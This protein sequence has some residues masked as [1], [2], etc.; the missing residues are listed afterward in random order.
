MLITLVASEG[1]SAQSA[2]RAHEPA[3]HGQ[4]EVP[5]HYLST[6]AA[7][8]T[9]GGYMGMFGLG[10]PLTYPTQQLTPWGMNPYLTQGAG[11]T[12][13]GMNPFSSSQFVPQQYG[14]LGLGTIGGTQ[15]L[16]QILPQVIQLLQ[17]VPQQLHQLQQVL[18]FIPAQLQQLQQL[19]QYVPQQIQQ[20]QQSQHQPFGQSGLG[21]FSPWGITPQGFGAQSGPVM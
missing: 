3:S 12:P 20:L 6:T 17:T 9:E 7:D 19:I 14:Q 4:H 21:G 11:T 18:Q 5:T 15:N 8:L 1:A 2:H 16:Q 10:T 13:F